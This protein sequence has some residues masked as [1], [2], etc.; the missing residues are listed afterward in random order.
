MN[1]DKM[2]LSSLPLQWLFIVIVVSIFVGCS[3]THKQRQDAVIQSFTNQTVQV[4]ATTYVDQFI[5]RC[6]DG[7]IWE[8]KVKTASDGYNNI[9]PILY[10]NCL[11]DALYS[12]PLKPEAPPLPPLPLE[13]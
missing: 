1:K 13:K 7:S 12:L 2:L 5:V 8:I 11:F 4:K 3:N 6:D 10:K 9:A